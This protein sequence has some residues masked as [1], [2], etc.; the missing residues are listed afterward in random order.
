[1]TPR[2]KDMSVYTRKGCIRDHVLRYR[3]LSRVTA[4][5]CVIQQCSSSFKAERQNQKPLNTTPSRW[6]TRP[7]LRSQLQDETLIAMKY[8]LREQI[9]SYRYHL[10]CH[11]SFYIDRCLYDAMFPHRLHIPT[12]IKEL[13]AASC[14]TFSMLTN[15]NT[16]L[17]KFVRYCYF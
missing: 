15:S 7:R 8:C 6:I 16:A 2:Q 12:N 10:F 3:S 13:E 14:T 9:W 4:I 5:F 17:Y 1:M 11:Y